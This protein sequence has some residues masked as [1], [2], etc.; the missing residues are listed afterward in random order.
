MKRKHIKPLLAASLFSLAPM[1][2]IAAVT[3]DLAAQAAA[4]YR[5]MARYPEWSQPVSGA[6][7]DP[8]QAGREAT[9]QTQ[10]RPAGAGPALSVWAS[11]IRYSTGDTAH[12]YASLAERPAS[13]V[14][15][16]APAP[17]SAAGPWAVT[18]E[19]VD[20]NGQQLAMLSYRDDGK[21]GDQQAGDGVY[22]ASYVL[23]AT[24]QPDLGSAKNIAIKVTAVNADQ[25]QRVALGGFL[26]SQ[27][28][29]QLTGEYRDRLSEGSLVVAAKVD[30]AVAGR[31]HLAGVLASAL[32][33]SLSLSQNAVH[34]EPGSHWVDLSFYGL[35]L[36]EA[37][38]SGPYTLSSVTL[39]TAGAMPN[40]LGPVV[41]A[42]HVTKPYLNLQFTDK[43]FGRADLLD[44]AT[45]LEGLVKR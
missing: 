18:G 20:N 9:V 26:F 19:L 44:A 45:R 8:L 39:T 4:E 5:T 36:R 2:T 30:V 16:L 33:E 14:N 42:A 34:L 43:P 11:D 40:A 6:L 27:P 21:D 1:A 17:R 12:F 37:G 32:G 31:Y 41:T 25:D 38:V 10:A 7:A 15:L 13:S 28:G 35:I 22:T 24:H 3:P 29:A 23:P